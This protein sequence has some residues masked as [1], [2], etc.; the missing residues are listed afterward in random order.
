M[1][2]FVE[3]DGGTDRGRAYR[4]IILYYRHSR[5]IVTTQYEN[6]QLPIRSYA[7]LYCII[8]TAA[9]HD[10]RFNN[11]LLPLYFVRRYLHIVFRIIYTGCFTKHANA[12]FS[13]IT[14][15]YYSNFD[16]LIFKYTYILL[17]IDHVFKFLR[18]FVDKHLSTSFP[19]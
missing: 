19:F 5:L 14:P 10:D 6:L 12:L 4:P 13:P 15:C 8:F 7:Y 3:G 16:Y 17:K 9:A 11:K 18:F 2:L 1:M